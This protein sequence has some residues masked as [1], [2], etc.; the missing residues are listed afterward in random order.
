MRWICCLLLVSPMFGACTGGLDASDPPA[1]VD[2]A[3]APPAESDLDRAIMEIATSYKSF[4]RIDKRSYPSSL[5]AFDVSVYVQGDVADYRTA[6]PDST[7][8]NPTIAV[9][10]VIVREVHDPQGAIAKL[11]IMAK[12]PA[13]YDPSI[14]D[15]WWGEADPQGV[16]L[17]VDGTPRVG[18]LD[19]CHG[20][21]LPRAAEDYIFGVAKADQRPH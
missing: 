15:W 9:G 7:A 19:D 14:G 1:S 10:T 20:C 2:A 12:G 4:S 8:P 5:G 11:T 17:V 6:H 16:P 13:G 21:H 18:R 3:P